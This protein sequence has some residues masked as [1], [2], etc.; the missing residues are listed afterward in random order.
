MQAFAALA[1]ER[2]GFHFLQKGFNATCS[3]TNWPTS[4]KQVLCTQKILD[5]SLDI[6]QAIQRSSPT[7]AVSL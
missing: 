6:L 2:N 4:V 5:S 1:K 3:D 7:A